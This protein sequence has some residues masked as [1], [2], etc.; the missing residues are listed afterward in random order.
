MKGIAIIG[1]VLVHIFAL[2][3]AGDSGRSVSPVFQ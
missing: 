1:I 3:Q 2:E